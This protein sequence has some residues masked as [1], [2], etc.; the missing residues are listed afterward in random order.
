MKLPWPRILTEADDSVIL[1]NKGAHKHAS[2][3]EASCCFTRKFYGCFCPDQAATRS[4]PRADTLRRWLRTSRHAVALGVSARHQRVHPE[5]DAR[6]LRALRE[7]SALHL[8]LQRRES[9]SHDEGVLACGLCA[10]EA[11]RRRGSLVSRR[12]VDGRERR[13][14]AV[15]RVDLPANTLRQSF[16]ST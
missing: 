5:D 14:R 4:Q 12:L 16:L 13:K 2:I 6:Q 1:S 3:N 10:R 11:V 8:Q 9:L 15:G 7:V